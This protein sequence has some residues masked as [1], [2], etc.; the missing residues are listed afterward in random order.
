MQNNSIPFWV[1]NCLES[2]ILLNQKKKY[3]G[4]LYR[5]GSR[6]TSRWQ[7]PDTE[8][9]F[10][11]R[12][13]S[14]S[15]TPISCVEKSSEP[16]WVWVPSGPPM[17]PKNAFC[18]LNHGFAKYCMDNCSNSNCCLCIC[19]CYTLACQNGGAYSQNSHTYSSV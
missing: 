7:L 15:R 10:L 4:L 11:K 12:Q 8:C 14:K 2:A 17:A 16:I 18:E 5:S 9:E 3:K 1:A 13:S 6:R 19:N